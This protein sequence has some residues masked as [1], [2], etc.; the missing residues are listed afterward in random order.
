MAQTAR[1]AGQIEYQSF[2][3]W[4]CPVLIRMKAGGGGGG[5]IS[6]G[7]GGGGFGHSHSG[8]H[9]FTDIPGMIVLC[10]ST[11]YDAK[12]QLIEA[13]RTESPVIYLERGRL[14]RSAPPKDA[15]GNVIGPVAELWQVPDGYY[16]IPMRQ[17][18]R[19][20][21]GT[22]YLTG[23]IV[24]WGTMMLEA[25]IAASNVVREYGGAFDIVDLRTLMPFDEETISAAVREAN[26]VV[27]VTE[28]PDYTT[29]GRHVH[30]WIVQHHFDDMDLPPAFICGKGNIPS[31]P[32]DSPEEMAFYPTSKDIEA[33]LITFATA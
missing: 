5:P 25:A 33:V 18:R 30:S 17:A 29:F 10:P 6:S 12:G 9:W 24:T 7:A 28:E 32:Y 15:Q 27:V 4:N 31:V 14:Y 3:D 22:G 16:T 13:S 26:R 23:A 8:E 2:G 20:R 21:I 19:I 1:L 11:P